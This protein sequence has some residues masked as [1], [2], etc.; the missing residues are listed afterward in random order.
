MM[1]RGLRY[2]WRVRGMASLLVIYLQVGGL[3]H[4]A[5]VLLPPVQLLEQVDEAPV[6][7]GEETCCY[8]S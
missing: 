7:G 2:L 3:D 5:G 6:K 4:E 1:M 8:I